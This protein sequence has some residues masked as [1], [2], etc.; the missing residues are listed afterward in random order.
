MRLPILISFSQLVSTSMQLNPIRYPSTGETSLAPSSPGSR[1]PLRDKAH[2]R[3]GGGALALQF[4]PGK[5]VWA[6]Q[7]A[8][9]DG[10]S[11][12]H[13]AARAAVPL[14]QIR[15]LVEDVTAGFEGTVRRCAMALRSQQ[16]VCP[17]LLPAARLPSLGSVPCCATAHGH[18][19]L[20]CMPGQ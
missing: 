3:F 18:G 15:P 7:V 1:S 4:E 5:E 11:V 17:C 19:L 9:L 13:A 12:R 10:P 6:V 20:A 8:A 16:H 14:Y 2:V